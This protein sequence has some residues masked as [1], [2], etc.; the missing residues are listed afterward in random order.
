MYIG[1]G[2]KWKLVYR[3]LHCGPTLSVK[4]KPYTTEC[5]LAEKGNS[6][7]SLILVLLQIPAV[8]EHPEHDDLTD[9]DDCHEVSSTVEAN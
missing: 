1:G 4:E 7:V 5:I 6:V 3:N 8:E 2:E 9:E